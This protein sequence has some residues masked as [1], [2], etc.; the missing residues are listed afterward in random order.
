MV[1]VAKCCFAGNY[2]YNFCKKGSISFTVMSQW[3][4]W[5]AVGLAATGS[6][7][8]EG[9]LR[10]HR[11]WDQKNFEP[12]RWQGCGERRATEL[13]EILGRCAHWCVLE[14]AVT[15]PVLQESPL[16]LHLTWCIRIKQL[17]DFDMHLSFWLSLICS[18]A[19]VGK[20]RGKTRLEKQRCLKLK[21][22]NRGKSRLIKRKI[23]YLPF[24]FLYCAV[25][26]VSKEKVGYVHVVCHVKHTEQM[27][28]A[29]KVWRRD[30]K[31]N[32]LRMC[33]YEVTDLRRL[34]PHKIW[35]QFSKCLVWPTCWIPSKTVQVNPE[36]LILFEKQRVPTLRFF[37]ILFY[38][39]TVN[40]TIFESSHKYSLKLL[41][42][43]VH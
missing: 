40:F 21:L 26:C 25:C 14:T 11:G 16:L 18:N 38:F 19:Q 28:Y 30:L 41:K 20:T 31:K 8:L 42:S 3:I 32:K 39:F 4:I 34:R 24:I 22:V 36:E 12:I 9:R 2:V 7:A 23:R 5:S 35:G 33:L 17:K 1:L 43:T 29:S 10:L 37:F 6:A 13:S 27:F 15:G